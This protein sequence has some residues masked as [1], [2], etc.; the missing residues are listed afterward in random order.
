MPTDQELIKIVPSKRQLKYQETE[1]Y[2]FFHFGMNTYTNREWGDGTE[3]PGIFNPQ[4]F[5]AGQ[6]VSAVK[7]AGMKGVILTCKHH[8]GF[9]LWPTKYTQHSVASSPWKDGAG[10]VVREVSDACRRYGLKFGIYLS[11]WDRNQPCYGSG[12]EY[13]DYYIAQL[14]E[15]LTGYGE[16]FSVWLDGAC[17]EGP[18]GKKQVYD[19]ERYYACVRKY[20]PDACICV[21]GPDIRWCGNEAGDVRKSEWSVVPARTA[22]AE[23]VQERSQQSDDE[24]FRL[25][26]ITS[27]ME[28]LGS[29]IA[30][31]G[32]H[33]LIWY[34]AEVNTSIRP[35]W[36]YHS[37]EDDQ[38]K[39]LEE[40]VHIYL[41]SVGGNAT[42][43]LNIPPMPNGLLH[44]N[45][46]ERLKELGEWQKGSFSRNLLEESHRPVE[47]VFALDEA[48][49]AGY[50]VLKEEIRY[51]QRVEAFE[52]FVRDQGEWEKV[53]TGTVIGYKK[54]IPIFKENVREI[55]IVLN[56]YRVLPQIS[57]VGVYPRNYYQCP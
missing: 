3:D 20:Q 27:D 44:E 18:N 46:V 48:E 15:L 28:D 57:F 21:C 11:P 12:K 56:D 16:I 14:T 49:D 43:L 23:S 31:E 41:G 24:E 1:F 25:R 17:G 37:E 55:R 6:W 39:S 34:P 45:D 7:A 13:D 38:V 9:C 51:S 35:G 42:F 50:L 10:D 53:Y 22:L 26:K 5:D 8:D 30:L 47:L 36:F 19:W 52:V 32:E 2:A 4:E 33:D 40:L 54:I 29:R